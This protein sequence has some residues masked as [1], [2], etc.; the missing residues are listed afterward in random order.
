VYG[1]EVLWNRLST[2][3]LDNVRRHFS[4]ESAREAVK[5]LLGL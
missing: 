5:R 2:Q 1:D 3:G 4:F